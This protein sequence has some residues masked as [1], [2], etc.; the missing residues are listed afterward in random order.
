MDSHLQ[1]SQLL[2]RGVQTIHMESERM[3]SIH[4]YGALIFAVVPAIRDLSDSSMRSFR[5]PFHLSRGLYIGPTV[6]CIL[7]R[8]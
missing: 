5:N 1:D 3:R 8:E 6:I 7:V 4:D 2:D